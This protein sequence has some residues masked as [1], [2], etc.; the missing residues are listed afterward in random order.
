[1]K[2]VFGSLLAWTGTLTAWQAHIEWFFKIGA[3]AA[4]ILVSVLTVRSL[5]RRDP[6]W[7]KPK[8]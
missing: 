7:T 4:A 1:M 6:L 2:P 8:E 5:L 3:S